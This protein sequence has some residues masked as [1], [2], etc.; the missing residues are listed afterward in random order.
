MNA[1]DL[2]DVIRCV[3]GTLSPYP[4]GRGF[5]VTVPR[6]E[7]LPLVD[8]A[9][10]RAREVLP[11]LCAQAPSTEAL[12]DAFHA[13]PPGEQELFHDC[14]ECSERRA[15]EGF[16]IHASIAAQE[17]IE[18]AVKWQRRKRSLDRCHTRK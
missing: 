4:D 8:D 3:G 9:I 12:A 6:S 7:L 1:S 16:A 13:L 17:L 18:S 15:L 14:P 5:R 10:A 2:I 11:I